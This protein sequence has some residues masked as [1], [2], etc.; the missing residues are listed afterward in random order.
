MYKSGVTYSDPPKS[1]CRL[2]GNHFLP[3]L[4]ECMATSCLGSQGCLSYSSP[5]PHGTILQDSLGSLHSSVLLYGGSLSPHKGLWGS[6]CWAA[7]AAEVQ[8]LLQCSQLLCKG[9]TLSC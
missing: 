5:D 2:L 9:Q 3:C 1:C 8:H 6:V 4:V 7:D